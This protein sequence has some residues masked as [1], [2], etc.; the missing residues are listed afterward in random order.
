MQGGST[1]TCLQFWRK[2]L[3]SIMS[4]PIEL[5]SEAGAFDARIRERVSHGHI[6]DLR[7][8]RPC[9]WFYN[10]P[11]RRPAFV[12]MV[13]GEY[14]RFA[15]ANLGKLSGRVLEVGCGPGH[16][17]LEMSRNGWH[18]TGLDISRAALNA[19]EKL[20]GENPF[21]DDFGSLH[22]VQTDFLTWHADGPYDAVCFFLTLHHF[23]DPT[24][25]LMKVSSLLSPGGRIVVIEPVRDWYGQSE[26][27]I[28]ALIRILLNL[29]GSWYD[30]NLTVPKDATALGAYVRACL[31][32]YTEA[33][34]CH[35]V[36]Q[37]PHDNSAYANQMLNALRVEFEQ[38]DFRKGYSFLHR[39][40][41][42]VR[43]VDESQTERIAEFLK[44]F[45]DFCVRQ[46]ILQPGVFYYAGSKRQAT[47]PT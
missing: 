24:V 26:G 32:E 31:L 20:L 1:T 30:Q 6:P 14:F 38:V 12:D 34:D 41:G 2:R 15:A 29:T 37:S 35:E 33:K 22:Y 11:W 16:M 42:G 39:M 9:D 3:I 7:R 47:A 23:E 25:V 27:A 5:Q 28:I 21:L 18:V 19:G 46:N 8:A 17:S 40:I 10:N 44:L 45:D 36:P 43:S 13:F 4:L